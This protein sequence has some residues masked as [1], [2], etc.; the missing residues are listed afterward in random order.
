MNDAGIVQE[1]VTHGAGRISIVEGVMGLFDGSEVTSDQ[2][3][4]M[5][6][7]RLLHWP[8]ILVIPSAK[9]GRSLAAALRGFMAEAGSEL[10]AGVILNGVSGVQP[11]GVFARGDRPSQVAGPGSDSNLF[12]AILA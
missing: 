1:T 7:A 9:A 11:C 6:M 2:G 5:A 3:S 12:G 4:T 10:V 8:V